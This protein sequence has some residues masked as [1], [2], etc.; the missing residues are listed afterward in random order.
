M[1][2]GTGAAQKAHGTDLSAQRHT[3][4]GGMGGG[5]AISGPLA[6]QGVPP[7]KHTQELTGQ[8]YSSEQKARKHLLSV[9]R[10]D[11]L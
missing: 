3:P 1:F 8:L 5:R 11:G 9:G 6:N 10:K 4:R 7:K 2:Y